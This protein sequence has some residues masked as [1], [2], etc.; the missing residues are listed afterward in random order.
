MHCDCCSWLASGPAAAAATDAD[1]VTSSHE[2]LRHHKQWLVNFR[3]NMSLTTSTTASVANQ[4]CL[5]AERS[6]QTEWSALA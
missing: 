6:I 2:A 4:H 5:T 1:N 3:R